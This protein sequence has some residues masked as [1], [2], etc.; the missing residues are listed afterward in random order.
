MCHFVQLVVRDL[1]TQSCL[2][3]FEKVLQ[4]MITVVNMLE[5]RQMA[6]F[7]CSQSIKMRWLSRSD[8]LNGLLSRETQL[9]A[10][11]RRLFPQKRRFQFQSIMARSY[12]ATL[13]ISH[14]I[15]QPFIQTVKFFEWDHVTL[16]H[17]YRTL[18]TVKDHFL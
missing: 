7:C 2:G 3:N 11:N 1:I 17:A 8:A 4:E 13:S 10:M 14:R 15:L 18:K 16:C 12:F 5:V 9:S 6:K